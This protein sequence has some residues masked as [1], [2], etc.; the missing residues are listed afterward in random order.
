MEVAAL[1]DINEYRSIHG[2]SMAFRGGVDKRAMARGG[3]SIRA[4]MDRLVPVIRDGG[5]I[6][7]CDHGV[8][9][10]VSWPA[11]VEYSRILAGMTGWL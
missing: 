11:F 1:N 8:P 4:E 5:Y 9:S 2:T 3:E 10:D 6:P 7:S